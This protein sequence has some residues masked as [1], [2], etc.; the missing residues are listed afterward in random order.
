MWNY[1]KPHRCPECHNSWVYHTY[2]RTGKVPATPKWWK[3][4]TCPICNTR[5]TGRWAWFPKT[6]C[7]IRFRLWYLY[8]ELK[9]RMAR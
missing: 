9:W 6:Y 4:Y 7:T 8:R 1:D 5:F 3:T 2:Y